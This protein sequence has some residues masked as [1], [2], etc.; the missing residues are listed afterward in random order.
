MNWQNLLPKPGDFVK[1]LT[2]PFDKN[3]SGK[4]WLQSTMRNVGHGLFGDTTGDWVDT[5]ILKDHQPGAPTQPLAVPDAL[6]A[7][8]PLNYDAEAMKRQILAALA[9]TQQGQQ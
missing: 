4:P 7:Q 9:N 3:D 1:T 6:P 5:N 2:A 8:Q